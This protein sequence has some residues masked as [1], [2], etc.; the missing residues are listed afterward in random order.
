MNTRVHIDATMAWEVL[1]AL[2]GRIATAGLPLEVDIGPAAGIRLDAQ[3]DWHGTG[4][5]SAEARELFDL[6]IPLCVPGSRCIF[7]QLGQ[8][9]DGRIATDSGE[10]RYITGPEDLLHLHR[11][12]ALADA[13]VIGAGTALADDPALTVRR[14]DGTNPVRVIVD[15]HGRIPAHL[16]VFHDDAAPT[17]LLHAADQP[18]AAPGLAECV[19][20]PRSADG[21]APDAIIAALTA[22]GLGRVLVEGGGITVSRFLAAGLLDRLHVTVAPLIIGSG[23][24]AFALPVIDSLAAARRPPWR[25]FDMGEDVLYDLVVHGGNRV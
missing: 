3:G 1:R 14:T 2:P 22:R 7:A 16:G 11:L 10:S 5:I 24:S 4:A 23:R 18:R 13:V 9:L 20:V 21:L 25:R 19:A 15:T 17:L 6:Y 8:S 12:R